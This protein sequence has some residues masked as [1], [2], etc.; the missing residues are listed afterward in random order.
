[1]K[2]RRRSVVPR[3]R[4]SVGGALRRIRYPV[5]SGRPLIAPRNAGFTL[6][7]VVI[8]AAILGVLA[9]AALPLAEL[10]VKRARE[11]ELRENLR[12][13]RHAID[14]YKRAWDDGR[15]ARLNNDTGYP[16]TLQDLVGGVPDAQSA[17]KASI[18]FL[19]R[20]PR[21]PFAAKGVPAAESWGRRSY[22]SPPDAPQ[23]GDDVY[24]VYSLSEDTGLNGIPY[25]DW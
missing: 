9:T 10:S 14:A 20:I 15:L 13:I 5:A 16:H 18:Y 24:D 19:R 12:E 2:A 25:K 7:E 8:T 22:A 17:S 21:D 3:E 11:I 1:M 23:E 6:L 4:H